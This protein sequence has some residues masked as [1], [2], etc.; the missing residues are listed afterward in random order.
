MNRWSSSH[1]G[2]KEEIGFLAQRVLPPPK[3]NEGPK[4][5][6]LFTYEVF[7]GFPKR[8]K[9]KGCDKKGKI[10]NGLNF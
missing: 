10:G 6:R 8:E 7:L 4:A 1:D 5:R 3:N 9:G 2:H